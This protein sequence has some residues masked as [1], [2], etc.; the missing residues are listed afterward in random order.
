MGENV[1]EKRERSGRAKPRNSKPPKLSFGDYRFIDVELTSDEKDDFRERLEEGSFVPLSVTDY[2]REGYTVKF[3]PRDGGK[4]VVCT[5]TCTDASHQNAGLSISGFAGDDATAFSLVSY[6][7]VVIC[8]NGQ[9][10]ASENDRGH[11]TP[12]IG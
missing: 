1:N 6:K 12:R 9:W 4:T 3:S 8:N 2:L 11:R 10:L 5:L 7:D